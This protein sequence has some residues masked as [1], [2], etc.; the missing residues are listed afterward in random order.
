VFDSSNIRLKGE[1][2]YYSGNCDGSES[3]RLEIAENFIQALKS[4]YY[5]SV[6]IDVPECN[7]KYVNV[8]CGSTTTRRRRNIDSANNQHV[9]AKRQTHP[10]AYVVDFELSVPF[11]PAHSQSDEDRF[12]ELDDI[13]YQ[14]VTV[15][16][17][18]VKSGLFNID[19]FTTD[20]YSI[21]VGIAEYDCPPGMRPKSTNAKCSM[22]LHIIIGYS[23]KCN[24]LKT[25]HFVT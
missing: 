11:Q 7:A 3:V 19:G 17:S 24:I 12:D 1:F 23:G 20:D 25:C 15:L 13:L 18:E 9:I 2:F 8:T 6:C 21:G 4:S 10:Y 22:Y 14:M 16:Q 5:R